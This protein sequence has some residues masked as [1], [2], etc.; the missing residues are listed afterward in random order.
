MTGVRAWVG[1]WVC[2]G[3]PNM[4]SLVGSFMLREQPCE[5]T[6]DLKFEGPGHFYHRAPLSEQNTDVRT[7]FPPLWDRCRLGRDLGM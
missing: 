5:G 1:F 4:V 7:C 2:P 3:N 6:Q